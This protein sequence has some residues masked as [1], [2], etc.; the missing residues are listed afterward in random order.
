MAGASPSPSPHPQEG[1]FSLTGRKGSSGFTKLHCIQPTPLLL[2]PVHPNLGVQAFS[3][4]PGDSVTLGQTPWGRTSQ[5][6]PEEAPLAA[7]PRAALASE[8]DIYAGSPAEWVQLPAPPHAG[9]PRDLTQEPRGTQ[10]SSFPGKPRR[11]GCAGLGGM[12]PQTWSPQVSG[13]AHT[14]RLWCPRKGCRRTPRAPWVQPSRPRGRDT[15]SLTH[16]SISA[17]VAKGRRGDKYETVLKP[18]P[19]HEIQVPQRA[20]PIW[21]CAHSEKDL[22]EGNHFKKHMSVWNE[23]A[24]RPCHPAQGTWSRLSG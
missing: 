2:P 13:S 20:P 15:Y 11:A 24:E 5:G 1:T 21:K 17:K 6:E 10:I 14:G 22:N 16:C 23:E 4:H 9:G 7:H 12:A 3:Q 8:G 18:L 19:V